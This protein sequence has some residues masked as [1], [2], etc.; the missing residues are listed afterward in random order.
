M[1]LDN[2][3]VGFF[4]S[5]MA[6]FATMIGLLIVPFKTFLSE[7]MI[8][9][10]LL[11]AAGA[12]IL[13][14]VFEIIIVAYKS[15]LNF[16]TITE[17]LTVGILV[18]LIFSYIVHK[19]DLI[20]RSLEK[21]AILVAASLTLHNF[22]EGSIV[23]STIIIDFKSG[24]ITAL[25]ITLHNIPEGL[26][27]AVTAMAAGMRSKKIFLLVALSTISE[28]LGAV[29]VLY[30]SYTLSEAFFG[31]LLIVVAGI[32]LGVAIA[33]LIPNG[34]RSLKTQKGKRKIK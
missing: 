26:V 15:G 21:S 18:V 29:V 7:R 23:I 6:A 22:P 1:N 25:A 27:I 14:S 30:G 20:E 2:N 32:M 19:L 17:W 5:C 33:E 24:A 11:F 3:L 12:M 8:A 31:N 10:S 28:I 9:F 16:F 34:V 4:V 13:V